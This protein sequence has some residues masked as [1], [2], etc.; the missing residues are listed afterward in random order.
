MS[1]LTI[2]DRSI[3]FTPPALL[4]ELLEKAGF[5]H[6]H[7]CGGRGTCGKCAVNIEGQLAP[8]TEAEI[9][10]G[11]RLSCQTVLT[12]D[13]T[14]YPGDTA[15][16][17]IESDVTDVPTGTDEGSPQT[18]SDR[19]RRPAA[20]V[21]I[22]TTTVVVQV[23]DLIDGTLLG[24]AADLN[25]QTSVA[26]DVMGR[27]NG[28]LNGKDKL[29]QKQITDKLAEL[30][31]QAAGDQY[32]RLERM[33]VTG[34]TTMLYLLTG[35]SPE[36]LATAPFEADELFDKEDT[37]LGI[38]TY[39]P[40]CISAFVGADITC[41][42]LHSGICT[43]EETA[44]LCDIGTNGELALWHN[45]RLTVTSTA[46]GPVFEGAGIRQGMLGKGGAIERVTA[47]NG[48]LKCETIG[49][50]PPKGICGS[51]LIDAVAAGLELELIDET[52]YL[53][54][55][56]LPLAGDVALYG[57][58]IRNLQLA[59]SAIAAGIG[60]L[61]NQAKLTQVEACHIAGGF[62][63]HLHLPSAFRIGLLPNQLKKNIAVIGN[64]ALAGAAKLLLHP[65]NTKELRTLI[66]DA[67]HFELG[68]DPTF[69]EL[70][71]DHMYF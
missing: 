14:L 6:A 32:E 63:K 12:G 20:A 41:A 39:Y 50:L 7:P 23:Y 10:A 15:E 38:P 27:I 19:L 43:K 54:Q 5:A 30:L 17:Q 33:V 3:P 13:A 69:N 67:A 31:H 55:D 1:I 11:T 68:G 34:N 4:S 60:A 2:H 52:G 61:L 8:L 64:A 71:I 49:K 44:L 46:A 47:E 9:K 29:L 62:G 24:T 22:G 57:E 48:A 28:A 16:M 51:G 66:V 65:E 26:A 56:P 25:P 21:D 45:G 58:D 37:L 40:P 35:R 42:L 70:Y 53:E 18:K 59:K 36:S